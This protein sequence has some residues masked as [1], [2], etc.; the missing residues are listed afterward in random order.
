MRSLSNRYPASQRGNIP[1]GQS[2]PRPLPRSF[3]KPDNDNTPGTRKPRPLPDND[4]T[5]GKRPPLRG[6]LLP[7]V[8]RGLLRGTALGVA[9]IEATEWIIRNSMLAALLGLDTWKARGAW[10]IDHKCGFQPGTR[11]T[12]AGF[13]GSCPVNA[14]IVAGSG[15]TSPEALINA[16]PTTVAI[17]V[18]KLRSPTK[19]D[20]DTYFRRPLISDPLPAPALTPRFM[21]QDTPWPENLPLPEVE[22]WPVGV[23]YPIRAPAVRPLAVSGGNSTRDSSSPGTRHKKDTGFDPFPRRPRR[24]EKERKIRGQGLVKIFGAG[25]SNYSEVGDFIDCIWDALPE[26]YQTPAKR[27]GEAIHRNSR[28]HLGDKM[29]DLYENLDKVDFGEAVKNLILNQIEDAVVGRL[30][31]RATK[32]FGNNLG[33]ALV[34]GIN[35]TGIY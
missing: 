12:N 27:A 4:N 16:N 20:R 22:T 15:Y 32:T 11:W 35:R 7:R 30:I 5:P 13:T 6:S 3:P 24:G 10:Y 1:V 14:T 26:Q 18:D 31:G 28:V 9:S 33:N 17:A 34:T 29:M 21:V 8:M 2:R 19:I 23:P 25:L